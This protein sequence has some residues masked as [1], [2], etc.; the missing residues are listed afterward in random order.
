[1]SVIEAVDFDQLEKL[2]EDEGDDGIHILIGGWGTSLTYCGK[3]VQFPKGM[4]CNGW[5]KAQNYTPSYCDVCGNKFC[6]RC[7]EL[8]RAATH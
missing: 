1:M 7:V 5:L 6:P 8:R 4:G 3:A 2:F